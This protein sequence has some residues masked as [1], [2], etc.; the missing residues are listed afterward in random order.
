[1]E[2]IRSKAMVSKNLI[3]LARDL[4]VNPINLYDAIM[5]GKNWRVYENRNEDRKT[6]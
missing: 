1:M 2:S 4:G 3:V 5:S 6:R